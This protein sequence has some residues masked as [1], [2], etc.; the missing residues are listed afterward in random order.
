MVKQ[1]QL[2]L[3]TARAPRLSR[4]E[5]LKLNRAKL[6]D[7]LRYISSKKGLEGLLEASFRRRGES[8]RRVLDDHEAIT[9][10]RAKE[11]NGDELAWSR[12]KEGTGDERTWSRAKEGKGDE[13]RRLESSTC[14]SPRRPS[15]R[16]PS[17]V[18]GVQVPEGVEVVVLGVP[19]EPTN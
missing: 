17:P 18:V 10:R 4:S 12:A 9:G 1:A 15:T 19:C 5:K 6:A 14:P 13:L 3:K 11:G 2:E 7:L 8:T 16:A